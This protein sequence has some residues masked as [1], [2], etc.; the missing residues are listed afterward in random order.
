M[1]PGNDEVVIS[2][3]RDEVA[4]IIAEAVLKMSRPAGMSATEALEQLAGEDGD[5]AEGFRRA[6]IAA[7]RHIVAE[8]QEQLYAQGVVE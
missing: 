4:I 3:S 7:T 2:I 6:A 1:K 8:V 5:M